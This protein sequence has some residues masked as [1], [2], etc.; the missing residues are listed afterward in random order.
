MDQ[1][2]TAQNILLCAIRAAGACQ[3]PVNTVVEFLGTNKASQWEPS[4]SRLG[5]THSQTHPAR[6]TRIQSTP[7]NSTYTPAQ[8]NDSQQLVQHNFHWFATLGQVSVA[9][10][11][12]VVFASPCC[13]Q[14]GHQGCPS[15]SPPPPAAATGTPTL[16]LPMLLPPVLRRTR[17]LGRLPGPLL[18]LLALPQKPPPF[19]RAVPRL[20]LLLHVRL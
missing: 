10:V 17:L 2:Q 1:Q 6:S 8:F 11:Q 16:R 5:C 20:L 12:T 18:L 3:L 19:S 4:S 13:C 15:A 14:S 9:V 7:T